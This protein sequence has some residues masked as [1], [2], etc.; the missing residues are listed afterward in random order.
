MFRLAQRPLIAVM[1]FLI[2]L[3]I[4][5]HAQLG[6]GT[7]NGTVVDSTGA[8]VPGTALTLTN[9]ETNA[10]RSTKTNADGNFS[11]RRYRTA[12]IR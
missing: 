7:V 1:V 3:V 9:S 4:S 11:C 2:G 5:A 8:V 6:T 10:K 12:G